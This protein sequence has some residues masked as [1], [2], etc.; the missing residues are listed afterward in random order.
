LYLLEKSIDKNS[1]IDIFLK[2]INLD[3][4]NEY[5]YYEFSKYKNAEKKIGYFDKIDNIL[6]EHVCV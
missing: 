5:I 3:Q 1:L 4:W 2:Q 6:K